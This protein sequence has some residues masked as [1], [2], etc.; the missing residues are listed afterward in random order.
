MHKICCCRSQCQAQHG[1]AL[2]ICPKIN[3]GKNESKKHMLFDKLVGC[4]RLRKPLNNIPM[5]FSGV[6]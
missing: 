1:A 6:N 4:G 2:V 5:K 3:E